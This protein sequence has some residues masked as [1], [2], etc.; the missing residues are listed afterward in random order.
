[1]KVGGKFWLAAQEPQRRGQWAKQINRQFVRQHRSAMRF[2][3]NAVFET[4][5]AH[6]YERA[7]QVLTQ[8][9]QSVAGEMQARFERYDRLSDNL[10]SARSPATGGGTGDDGGAPDRRAGVDMLV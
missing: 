3:A 5:I 2:Y 9:A 4:N 7:K 8:Y 6:G 1:M 10:G